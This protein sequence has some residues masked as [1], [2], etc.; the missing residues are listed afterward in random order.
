[1]SELDGVLAQEPAVRVLREAIAGDRLAGS[2]LFEGPGGVGKRRTAVALA[3]DVIAEGKPAIAERIAAGRH[4]DVRVFEPRDEGHR[5]IQVELVRTEILPVAQFGPFEAKATFLIF[6]EADVSFPELHPEAA[7]ALLK[8][9]EE[10]RRGIHFVLLAER[11]DRLLPTIR[12]RCQS[13]RFGPLPPAVLTEILTRHEVDEARRGAAVA[14]ADGRA[15]RALALAE[16]GTA[17]ELLDLALRVDSAVELRKPGDLV[18]V[19]EELA[20]DGRLP[21]VLET[22]SRFYRDVACAALQLP[23]EQLCFRHA[24][25]AIRERAGLTTA[26]QAATRVDL[27][28]DTAD[29]LEENANPQVAM[30]ALLFGLRGCR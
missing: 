11:P 5:N 21:L 14:L 6:P 17:D 2:Y 22:L 25:R 27:I 7:N 20:R 23:D 19:A 30:D 1:M 24:A 12:S 9:L 29:G 16:E 4:P 10:P 15:D 26:E 8:T 3:T 28:R 18:D 13:L